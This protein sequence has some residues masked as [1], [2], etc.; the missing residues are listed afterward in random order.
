MFRALAKVKRSDWFLDLLGD[1]ELRTEL[2]N[3]ATRLGIADRIRFV[4]FTDDPAEYFA[5]SDILLLS[6]RWEG[7]PAVP[8]E[9]LASG[10]QVIATDCS[11]GLTEILRKCDQAVVPIG[12]AD[13]M[14]RA[15]EREMA[16]DHAPTAGVAAA[17]RY[18]VNSS[19]EDHLRVVEEV[20]APLPGL[21]S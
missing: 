1:G 11:P 16:L 19:V 20:G 21:G 5:R 10:C 14:A 4:G 13:A 8:L 15:I 12:D 7:L 2:E 3:L 18:S 9:A 17:A 6:S